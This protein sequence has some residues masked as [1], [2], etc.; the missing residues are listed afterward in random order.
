MKKNIFY[1]ITFLLLAG[2]SAPSSQREELKAKLNENKKTIRDLKK[3]NLKI[4]EQLEKLSDDKELHKIPVRIETLQPRQFN[5]YILSSGILEAEDIAYM[6]PEVPAQIKTIHVKEGQRVKKGDL[7]VSLNSN[8]ISNSINEIKSNLELATNV[9]NK[10]KNLWDQKIGSEVEYLQAKT[11]KESLESSLAAQQAQLDLYYVRAPFSGIIDDLIAKE[12]ELSSPS[13]I[14]LQ[15]VNL[16]KMKINADVSE[17]YLPSIQARDTVKVNFPTYPDLQIYCPI[18]RTGNVIHP[19]NRTFNV[20]ITL[21]NK[22]EK[23]KPNMVATLEINDY[24]IENALIVPSTI[25]KND[26]TGKFL[27]IVNKEGNA[28]KVYVETGRSYMDKTVITS[29]LSSGNKV[30]VEGFNT[31]SNNAPVEIR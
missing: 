25:I 17:I 4:E 7:L 22:D 9:Y 3:E 14:L 6:R 12:G 13:S 27:F 11:Q 31:V 10:Q 29:G 20:Q 19:D 1:F 8:V 5:H 15:L 21:N 23:L 2:C 18:K 24:S 28:Q 26:I 30:I 16:S